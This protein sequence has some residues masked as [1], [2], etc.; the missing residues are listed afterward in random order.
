MEIILLLS[1]VGAFFFSCLIVLTK[2]FSNILNRRDESSLL[3]LFLMLEEKF[4][5]FLQLNIMLAI[6]LLY[7]AFN[8]LNYIL[9][10]PNLLRVLIQKLISKHSCQIC[11][12]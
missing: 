2:I 12:I 1:N 3:V 4:L 9:F 8:M 5:V 11:F 10:L 6:G 7:M